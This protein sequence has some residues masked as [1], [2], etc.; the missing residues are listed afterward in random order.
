MEH[1]VGVGRNDFDGGLM[2]D[3]PEEYRSSARDSLTCQPFGLRYS[4]FRLA[5][6]NRLTRSAE[7]GAVDPA[8]SYIHGSIAA[9]SDKVLKGR[10]RLSS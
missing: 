4:D 6:P 1:V 7:T 2:R 5:L 10:G 9:C 3:N 8:W